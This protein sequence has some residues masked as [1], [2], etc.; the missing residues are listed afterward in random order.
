MITLHELRE[1]L[2]RQRLPGGDE[3][4]AKAAVAAILRQAEPGPV[5]LLFIRRAEH[6]LDPWSGHMAFPGGRVDPGD[7]GPEAAAR[8]ETREELALDL[9][10]QGALIGR[11][12]QLPV[13]ARGRRLP[14]VVEPFVYALG[15]RPPALVLNHEVA[16]ALWVP[17]PFL[18][19]P[20]NRSTHVWRTADAA[21]PYPCYRFEGRV[22][23]GLTLRMVDDLLRVA[24]G[25]STSLADAP[26]TSRASRG[27]R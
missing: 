27:T 25:A 1:A 4:L 15:G 3:R 13:S 5:Q 20:G 18:A 22:I 9:D 23:W 10:R 21:V 11:L 8:R 17:L 2:G 12:P 14:M 6:P 26:G 7:A 24:A 16:E 19:D